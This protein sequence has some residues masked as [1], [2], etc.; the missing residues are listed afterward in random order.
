MQTKNQYEKK[1]DE[2]FKIEK[3]AFDDDNFK[4][5]YI[6]FELTYVLK[7]NYEVNVQNQTYTVKANEILIISSRMTH[8]AKVQNLTYAFSLVIPYEYFSYFTKIQHKTTT[9]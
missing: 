1:A 3:I 6:A 2:R 4:H 7:Y 9:C 5:F 8:S